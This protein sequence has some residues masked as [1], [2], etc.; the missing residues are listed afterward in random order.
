MPPKSDCVPHRLITAKPGDTWKLILSNSALLQPRLIQ[1]K[2]PL[3]CASR[4]Q[5]TG[6]ATVTG[7]ALPAA[8]HCSSRPD[9]CVSAPHGAAGCHLSGSHS[10]E[11]QREKER[12]REGRG[13][14]EGEKEREMCLVSS[15]A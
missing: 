1:A 8:P 3:Q 10:L 5:E 11:T 9:C 14:R 6:V 7:A 2:Q 4:C 15:L 13:G 12:D